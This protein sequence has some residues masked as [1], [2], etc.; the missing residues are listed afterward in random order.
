MNSSG[1]RPYRMQARA[2]SAAETHRRIVEA[3][4]RLFVDRHYDELSLAEVAGAA[5]VTVQT[6]LRRFGS[7]DGLI[8]AAATLGLEEVRRSRFAPPPGELDEAVRN[9]VAH[10]EAW[11]D[12]SVRFLSQEERVPAMKRLVTAGRALHQE[13]VDHAF[14]PY[15]RKARGPARERLRARLVAATD[16]YAWKIVRR[17]LG[18]DARATELTLRELLAAIL[19]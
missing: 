7:K 15:L 2:E 11:G 18:L 5:G 6:V 12:R 4:T 17:D 8:D 10:Y 1:S 16:V 9:L 19:A 3:A 13:W 14:G